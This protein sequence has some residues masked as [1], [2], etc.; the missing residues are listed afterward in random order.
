MS[1][2]TARATTAGV[3]L[4]HPQRANSQLLALLLFMAAVALLTTRSPLV[5]PRSAVGRG[6]GANSRRAAAGAAHARVTFVIATIFRPT[7]NRSLESVEALAVPADV[8]VVADSPGRPVPTL[9]ACSAPACRVVSAPP[10]SCP[11]SWAGVVRNAGVDHVRTPWVAFLDDD[12]VVRFSYTQRVAETLAAYPIADVIV[13]RMAYFRRIV[14]KAL[15]LV[16]GDVG[17]SYAMKT[18]LF[19]KLQFIEGPM[20]DFH[21]L[22]RAHKAGA[23][24]VLSRHI[25]YLVRNSYPPEGP[26][27]NDDV[28]IKYMSDECAPDVRACPFFPL[29]QLP[30]HNMSNCT[31]RKLVTQYARTPSKPNSRNRVAENED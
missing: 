30:V 3:P 9:P 11:L 5:L 4:R 10:T 29:H 20:E 13:F 27:D 21:L 12:D 19:K 26:P 25:E 8:L 18:R 2:A 15:D 22:Y 23:R 17:I 6:E 7:L 24:I 31:E 1:S 16:A 14:P 28:L